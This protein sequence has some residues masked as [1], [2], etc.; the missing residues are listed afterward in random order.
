MKLKPEFKAAL[1]VVG[2]FAGSFVG[3]KVFLLI[4]LQ[5][6]LWVSLAVLAYVVYST[7]LTIFRRDEKIAQWRNEKN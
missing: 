1:A 2:V 7:A 3:A 4:G 6:L 5:G